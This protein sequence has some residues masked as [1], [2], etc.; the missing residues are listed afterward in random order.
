MVVSDLRVV[1][2]DFVFQHFLSVIS[3]F[4]VGMRKLVE[5]IL[6]MGHKKIAYITGDST[7]VVTDIR[8]KGLKDTME[9]HGIEMPESWI[10]PS[11]Y[12][13]LKKAAEYTRELLKR[14]D[15]PTCIIYSDDYSAVGGIAAIESM[16]LKIPEDISVA[17]YDDIFIA[18]QLQPR[19]TTV[20]QDTE[21]IGMKAAEQ[22]I[23]L[24]EGHKTKLSPP[25]IVASKLVPGA[26]VR[27]LEDQ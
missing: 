19:L 26:S 13:N 10:L 20:R 3:D 22:L 14:E 17:G 9:E 18:S 24:I 4:A 1:S 12:R 11:E 7:S 21:R 2:F 5:Y 6:S 27:K 23:K 16:G 15:K 8:I 25:S